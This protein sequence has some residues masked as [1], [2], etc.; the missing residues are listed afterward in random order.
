VADILI[1]FTTGLYVFAI[2]GTRLFALSPASI[3][4]ALEF[5][6]SGLLV[7]DLDGL[8]LY[9]NGV[10]RALLKDPGVALDAPAW[11]LLAGALETSAG[12]VLSPQQLRERLLRSD[13]GQLF[14]AGKD[15][16][17]WLAV[18][19]AAIRD[20]RGRERAI[21][22]SL[23]DESAIQRAEAALREAQKLEAVGRLAG[24][25]AHDF[26]NLLT[27]IGGY[28]EMLA[29][30]VRGEDEVF[31]I[32]Q[33]AAATARASELTSQLL[34]FGRRAPSNPGRVDVN[35]LITG[36][37][38][39]LV[40]SLGDA[41]DLAIVLGDRL[42]PVWI[43]PAQLEQALV[44]LTLRAHDSI[45][46]SGR[47]EVS[48]AKELGDGGPRV[49]IDVRHVGTS[50]DPELQAH[51]FEPFPGPI[52]ADASAGRFGLEL[53]AAHGIA[54]SAGG[55]ISVEEAP[56]GGTLF[57]LRLPGL[58][59][60]RELVGAIESAQRAIGAASAGATILVVE[61]EASVRRLICSAL[62][63]SGHRLLEAANGA[64]ALSV[65]ASFPGRIDLVV[66]D[67]VMPV[68][69][70]AEM[71]ARLRRYRPELRVLFVSGYPQTDGARSREGEGEGGRRAG[72]IEL[73]PNAVL[74][75]KPF[76]AR[77]LIAA[78]ERA[79]ASPPA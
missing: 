4:S 49:R 35:A 48:T 41:C 34:A 57:R 63:G 46:E 17:R 61:D 7:V 1:P 45:G 3:Y 70:G 20:R 64:E 47:V 73:P 78:V 36:M 50:L 60:G 74:L 38:Q 18:H 75:A 21:C 51:P 76:R 72:R 9:A 8:V 55:D 68:M 44:M 69:D 27:V 30:S 79:L 62:G 32:E 15:V 52:R 5:Q 77:D 66:S 29:A 65:A 14:R 22:I 42:P 10:A 54:T 12:E 19:T 58:P 31:A 2:Y 6:P 39:M 33:I 71:A 23:D 40:R 67:V 56:E 11:A 43:D 25:I 59:A 13:E 28:N 37:R 53:A 16:D 24:G 26:N